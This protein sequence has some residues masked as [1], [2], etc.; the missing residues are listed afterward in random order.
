MSN[1]T[2]DYRVVRQDSDG[3]DLF[4]IFEVYY[5]DSHEPY[6]CASLPAKPQGGK[7]EE[8]KRD[9]QK[10]LQALDYEVLEYEQ[11]T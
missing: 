1:V 10:M 9:L 6:A 4:G 8:L 11:F 5:T 7:K 3:D 2:S